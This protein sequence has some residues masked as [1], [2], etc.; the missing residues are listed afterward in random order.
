LLPLPKLNFTF[1]TTC[2]LEL[3]LGYCFLNYSWLQVF[4]EGAS[5]PRERSSSLGLAKFWSLFTLSSLE[6]V[7]CAWLK[8]HLDF[9]IFF[10]STQVNTNPF[11]KL[12][13]T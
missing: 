4:L 10:G 7:L 8:H 3:P 11:R 5:S 9:L 1:S 6:F 2:I 12:R 13:N